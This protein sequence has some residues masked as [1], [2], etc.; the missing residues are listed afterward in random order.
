MSFPEDASQSLAVL[1]QLAVARR[2]FV[3]YGSCDFAEP[4]DA[5]S[6]MG[7]LPEDAAGPRH[8]A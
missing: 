6:A 8:G 2:L 4:I 5:L 7:G 3:G 1:S